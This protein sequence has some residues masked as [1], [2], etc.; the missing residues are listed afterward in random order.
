MNAQQT[1]FSFDLFDLAGFTA[2]TTVE[3]HETRQKR[4]HDA[5]VKRER[6]RQAR[7][8]ERKR[9]QAEQEAREER[10][11]QNAKSEREARRW[12]S[13]V[14]PWEVLGVG[15]GATKAEIRAA[16]TRLCKTHHPDA[17]GSL[18]R[19]QAVNRAYQSLKRG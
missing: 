17:G 19:M 3:D 11:Y 12:G 5:K 1:G 2:A 10:E 9:R 15:Y 13:N 8:E 14:N 4:D 16:W 7:E 6:E 18:E